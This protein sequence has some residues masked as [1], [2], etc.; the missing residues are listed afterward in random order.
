MVGLEDHMACPFCDVDE[1]KTRIIK[2]GKH[3]FVALSN[4][5]LVPCH[6]LVIPKRHVEKL[7]QLTKEERDELLE[8]LIEFEEKILKR[9]SSGC[10]IRSN[11]RPFL[12]ESRTKV[13]HL[14]FHLQPREFEDELYKKVERHQK[15]VWHD[16]SEEE[17]EKFTKLLST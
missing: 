3:C 13:N 6:I 11:F 9:F 5:Q 8:T 10:D 12:K 1:T 14:H 17:K 4:P 2:T 7:S 15:D 16:L